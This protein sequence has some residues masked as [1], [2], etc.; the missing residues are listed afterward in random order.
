MPGS[1]IN[2]RGMYMSAAPV[3]ILK[4]AFDELVASDGVI[5][6]GGGDGEVL[7]RLGYQVLTQGL[8]AHRSLRHC[9]SARNP[10]WQP[11]QWYHIHRPDHRYYPVPSK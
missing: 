4:D 5:V 11:L 1:N 3:V 2:T 8:E 10:D 6:G 9:L 7:R